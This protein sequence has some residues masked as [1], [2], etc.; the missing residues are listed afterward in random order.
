[1][2]K[3][4]N[5]FDIVLR[6]EKDDLIIW[7][8][9]TKAYYIVSDKQDEA[10]M[11]EMIETGEC[12]SDKPNNQNN[13]KL[14]DELKQIG[15]IG[16]TRRDIYSKAD[17]RLMSPLEYY[18]DYT[19]VCNLQCT[20][21]Y[22]R[23]NMNSDT[24]EDDQ[25]VRIIKDMYE[26]GVMRLHLAGGEPTLFPDKLDIYM[27]TA[28][29]YGIL[30]SMA[31]NGVCI[32]DEICEILTRND[33][34][35]ITISIE[36]ANE[37][38]NAKIRGKGS[39]KDS[40]DGIVHLA[41]YKKEHNSNYF[42]GIKVSY[43]VDVDPK[44]FEDLI[45]LA[46]EYNIDVLKFANPERCVFHERGYYG[47]KANKY[48]ENI[49]T[50]RKLKEKYD[51]DLLITQIVSPVTNC[52]DLG[53][54]NMRGCIGAQELIAINCRG[55]I[56]PCLMNLTPLGNIFE[57]DSIRDVYASDL[58]KDY[59]KKITDYDCGDC[60]VHAKCRGGCQVRKMVEYGKITGIDPLCPIKQNKIK[61]PKDNNIEN[62]KDKNDKNDKKDK[63][64]TDDK[65]LKKICVL[66]S[67]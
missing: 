48:Y 15:A 30:T 32:T 40:L 55:D 46:I 3:N 21:C 23:N 7:S 49:E 56:T 34:M 31:S 14:F 10:Q 58:I 11:L 27:K 67:L 17:N 47:K 6:H 62:K 29:E 52:L 1:M 5:I 63:Y 19:N 64:K 4:K 28:K 16:G 12:S 9:K 8:N 33:V 51:K 25:I 36:S 61:L 50:V 65:K 35:S 43:D 26:S 24:L 2:K 57:I 39:L 60:P 20:H 22:N 44:E 37:E 59:Y 38:E 42:I 53:L 66:H 18:F 13:Q 41:K 45:K 54:P